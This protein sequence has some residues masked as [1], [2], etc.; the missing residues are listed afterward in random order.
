MRQNQIDPDN[1]NYHNYP[2]TIKLPNKPK[3]TSFDK[4]RICLVD[5]STKRYIGFYNGQVK[6][7]SE[8]EDIETK[9]FILKAN[10]PF[11]PRVGE[12]LKLPAIKKELQVMDIVH[13]IVISNNIPSYTYLFVDY[14]PST[15]S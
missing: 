8:Y 15:N 9:P 6:L 14:I 2:N 4:Y 1:D 10:L 11:L 7:L 13:D 12:Y 5:Y 3:G